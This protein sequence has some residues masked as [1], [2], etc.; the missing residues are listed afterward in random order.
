MVA[1]N[2]I[3]K[4]NKAINKIAAD[5][6]GFGLLETVL[7]III[8]GLSMS[9]II[10]S[11]IVGSAKSVN[12]VNQETVVNIAKQTMAEINY[13]RNGGTVSGGVHEV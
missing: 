13:C 11:F 7:T 3:N 12:I 6:S 5:K 2:K 4:V 9:A 1:I 10:E 8:I